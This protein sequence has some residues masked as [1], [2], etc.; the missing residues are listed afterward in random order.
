MF[1]G[2]IIYGI[3]LVIGVLYVVM[4]VV[5]MLNL[6]N[7]RKLCCFVEVLV[8]LL[9]FRNCLIVCDCG[10]LLLC[11]LINVGVCFSLLIF[12]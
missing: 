7:F 3:V 11:D 10:N 4:V 12:F 2:L 9:L 8:S 6:R 5:V 1:F